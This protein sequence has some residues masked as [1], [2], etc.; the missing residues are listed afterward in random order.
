MDEVLADVI[1]KF[2]ALYKKNHPEEALRQQLNGEE[3][4]AIL[5][6]RI[7]GDF[8]KHI[9]E[10][11]FFRDLEVIKDS[12]RVVKELDKKYD[13]FIVSAA[14]E[15][16]NS[17]EDKVDWLADHFPFI[18]WQRTIFC[19]LKIVNVDIMIDDRSRN[20]VGFDGRPLLFSSPHNMLIT[21]FERVNTWEEVAAKL[22]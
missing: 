17:L 5:P 6:E 3:F 7:A 10:K 19:G 18:P 11:G 20:F 9:Y 22:L 21:E 12:Q 4:Y 2:E 15:F 8:R 14:M 13:V 16:R 1:A